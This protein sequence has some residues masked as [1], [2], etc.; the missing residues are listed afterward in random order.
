MAIYL[1]TH[2]IRF[3]LFV[4]GLRTVHCSIEVEKDQTLSN[5]IQ[6][7]FTEMR[8]LHHALESILNV[9]PDK[10]CQQCFITLH[11]RDSNKNQTLTDHLKESR[12]EN[13][14]VN[15]DNGKQSEVSSQDFNDFLQRL[16]KLEQS[17]LEKVDARL[18]SHPLKFIKGVKGEPGIPGIPGIPG[19]RGDRGYPGVNGAFCLKG[20]RGP[21]GITGI[22]G[23]K[24][25]P[26]D[27]KVGH[28]EFNWKK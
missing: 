8:T 28:L 11:D 4:Y 7:A 14:T 12:D 10:G 22:P 20:N 21:P 1:R 18:A 15:E 13:A 17:I 2:I 27:T 3:I 6:E 25:E 5:R 24:G 19:M 16:G 9:L 23:R 26:G